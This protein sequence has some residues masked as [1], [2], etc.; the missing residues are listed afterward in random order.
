[1]A[2]RET[3]RGVRLADV[4][5]SQ[6]PKLSSKMDILIQMILEM[7]RPE[8]QVPEYIESEDLQEHIREKIEAGHN[9]VSII[10]GRNSADKVL[11]IFKK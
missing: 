8:N 3:V 4:L 2:F 1:M 11:V 5:T 7:K 9:L 10:Y 6:L